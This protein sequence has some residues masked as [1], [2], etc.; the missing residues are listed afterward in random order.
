M[1]VPFDDSGRCRGH[2]LV[3][4]HKLPMCH[5]CGRHTYRPDAQVKPKVFR[6]SGSFDCENWKPHVLNCAP[7]S[8]GGTSLAHIPRGVMAFHPAAHGGR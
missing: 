5:T 6:V 4:G 3:A 7:A 2:V 1:A 8:V